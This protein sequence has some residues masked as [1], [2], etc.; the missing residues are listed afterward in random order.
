[1]AK[2]YDNTDLFWT[3]RGDFLIGGAGDLEDTDQDPLRS[4]IQEVKTRI[5]ADQGDWRLSPN[6]GS[7][8]SDFVGEPND[9]ITADNIRVRI[10]ATLSRD[11][12]VNTK[13]MTIK[14]MPVSKDHLLIRISFR[15]APTTK[16]KNSTQLLYNVLYNYSDN[17]IY[18][19]R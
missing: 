13:D 18:F 19:I 8:I 5:E 3:S 11:G 15:V 2:N 9:Q 12:F 7:S 6:L 14:Y 1:M 16:N 10:I 17:N 4:F